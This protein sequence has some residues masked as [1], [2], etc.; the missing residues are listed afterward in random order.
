M[1]SS[2]TLSIQRATGKAVRYLR[3][4]RGLTL[5]ELGAR[6]GVTK[7]MLSKWE[8]HGSNVTFET[9]VNVSAALGM[10]ASDFVRLA[11]TKWGQA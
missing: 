11:Q 8:N 7:S 10:P 6:A 5:A 9:L 1:P 4:Q 3:R 2:K